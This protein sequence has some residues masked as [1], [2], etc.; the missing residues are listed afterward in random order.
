MGDKMGGGH[1]LAGWL[2]KW[3][4]IICLFMILQI[5][6]EGFLTDL[7]QQKKLLPLANDEALVR[8]VAK[9][10][11]VAPRAAPSC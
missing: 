2:L 10:K 11:Q 4:E 1:S 3:G 8:D 9:V 6:G 7:S 5:I